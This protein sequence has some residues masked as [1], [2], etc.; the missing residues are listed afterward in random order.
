MLKQWQQRFFYLKN[1]KLYYFKE[2]AYRP[3]G[4]I[5]LRSISKVIDHEKDVNRFK[6]IVKKRVYDIKA[7]SKSKK[8]DW[9][10][11]INGNRTSLLKLTRPLEIRWQKNT[12]WNPDGRPSSVS[13]MKRRSLQSIT[14][15]KY[16]KVAKTGDL[17]LFETASIRGRCSYT[18]DL[19]H[20]KN[21]E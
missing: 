5:D 3:S 2:K 20:I 19:S 6:I 1:D 9:M 8:E 18:R 10:R 16:L 15:K 12:V 4:C 7:D 17:F 11:C 14:W 21:N 13:E